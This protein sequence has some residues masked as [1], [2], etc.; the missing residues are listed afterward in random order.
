MDVEA[1]VLGERRHKKELSGMHKYI[2]PYT[3]Q[4]R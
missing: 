4:M 2:S 3:A 1:Y